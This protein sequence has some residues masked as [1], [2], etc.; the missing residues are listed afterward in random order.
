MG[1]EHSLSWLSKQQE[2]KSAPFQRNSQKVQTINEAPTTIKHPNNDQQQS[3]KPTNSNRYA[4]HSLRVQV[5]ESLTKLHIEKLS[6]F[7]RL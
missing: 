1:C 3:H 5:T 7:T 6:D 4:T 2:R